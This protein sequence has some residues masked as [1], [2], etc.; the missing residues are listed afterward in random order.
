MSRQDV[1]TL[2]TRYLDGETLS[3][4]EREALQRGLEQDEGLTAVA[5]ED[6]ALDGLL[7]SRVF[8]VEA[9]RRFTAGVSALIT[10][11]TDEGRFTASITA[12]LP[13]SGRW[14]R[15][16][17]ATTW[18]RM[19]L[20]A[21]V[22]LAA[23]GAW[24]LVIGPRLP[25][26]DLPMLTAEQQPLS[27]G[28]HFTAIR[29]TALRWH[30]GT[31]A[32][33]ATGT[34]LVVGDARNGKQMEVV[35]GHVEIAAAPQPSKRPMIVRSAQATATVVGTAFTFDVGDGVARLAVQHGAVRFARPDGQTLLI[36][37]GESAVADAFGLRAPGQPIFAWSPTLAG[38]LKPAGGRIGSA[39]DGRPCLI[40]MPDQRLVT[41][42]FTRPEGLFAFDP[43][44][45]V[46]ARVWI[47]PTVRWAGFYMQ[48][49]Q[50]H[51]HAQWHLPLDRRGEWRDIRFTLAELEAINV[52]KL[53]SDDLVHILTLQ[54]Q[55]A[56]D[57]ELFLDHLTIGPVESPAH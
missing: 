54:A 39:P 57:A 37:L 27:A 22:M 19:A 45:V 43:S 5:R 53:V 7:R 1:L 8:D 28:E 31:T 11:Q 46:R 30:D 44:L 52:P 34:T 33:L 50:H 2:W 47:G 23:A 10:A 36:G 16:T 56:P 29:Q 24:W 32:T 51:H 3:P 12:R 55:F 18:V 6:W 9:G 35:T 42:T 15:R 21:S 25:T 4:A 41:M 40:A 38:A 48:D 13:R 26:S 20:A 17:P 49:Y 14:H